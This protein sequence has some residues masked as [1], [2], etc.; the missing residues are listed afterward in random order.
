MGATDDDQAK[1]ISPQDLKYFIESQCQNISGL[2]YIIP[3]VKLLRY[4]FRAMPRLPV[5]KILLS[6]QERP[7]LAKQTVC[8]KPGQLNI[9]VMGI[10]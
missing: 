3:L 8:L 1:T 10:S 6:E 9:E 2:S 5:R 7:Q 4:S